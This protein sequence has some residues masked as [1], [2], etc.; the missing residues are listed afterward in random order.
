MKLLSQCIKLDLACF[1]VLIL[2]SL[3]F[4]ATGFID[5]PDQCLAIERIDKSNV[6]LK[7]IGKC[8]GK[9]G[10]VFVEAQIGESRKVFVE[11]DFWSDQ[12]VKTMEIADVTGLLDKAEKVG[13]GV[14]IP[15][16]P[17]AADMQRASEEAKAVYDSP[18]FQARLKA[19]TERIKKA[20]IG[21]QQFDTYYKDVAG[22]GALIKLDDNERLYVFV[23]ASMPLSVLRTYAADVARLKDRH[24]TMV[25]RGFIGGMGQIGPTVGFV[26]SVIKKDSD[27]SASESE[28]CGMMGV[29]LVVDP[30]LFRK[31]GISSVPAFV[32]VKGLKMSNPDMS[33]GSDDNIAQD[34]EPYHLSGDAS[35]KYIMRRMAE[36][37]GSQSLRAMEKYL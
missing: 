28:S 19:E 10:R 26:S 23:S 8:V 4:A 36:S 17:H 13:Q 16:N 34:G 30:L 20:T 32:Y 12:D 15:E 18:E 9:A 1:L 11:G 31:Y 35:L 7:R 5:T 24:V 25:L 21:E 22:E 29:D 37:S 6:H 33:E 2:P 14:K 3:T 27:C